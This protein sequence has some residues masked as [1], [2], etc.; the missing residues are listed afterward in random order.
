MP[1]RNL[2]F[3]MS[4]LPFRGIHTLVFDFDGVF[5]DNLVYVDDRGRESVCCS[6]ED[7]YG[8]NL[9]KHHKKKY[10]PFLQ[11]FVLSTEPNKVVKLRCEKMGITCFSGIDNKGDFLRKWLRA[12]RPNYETPEQGVA[13]FGNDLNDL[14]AMLLSGTSFAPSGAHRVIKEIATFNL[15]SEGGSGF[16]R[17]GI[18]LSLGISNQNKEE[19]YESIFDS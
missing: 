17:E 5:T 7:S 16:V 11:F 9:L 15:P 1:K 13:Y 4:G 18:E 6:R 8:I 3:N 19:I 10:F 2:G 14:E 12:E